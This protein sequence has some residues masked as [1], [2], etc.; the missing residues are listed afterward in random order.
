MRHL[1][2]ATAL[3]AIST[4]AWSQDL[5]QTAPEWAIHQTLQDARARFHKC[6]VDHVPSA[7]RVNNGDNARLN[8]R[9]LENGR[10]DSAYFL[11]TTL[12][13][14]A[15]RTCVLDVA[16]TLD[17]R[18]HAQ[19]PLTIEVWLGLDSSLPNFVTRLADPPSK[20]VSTADL[21]AVVQANQGAFTACFATAAARHSRL[22][23]RIE[24]RA[25]IG[26]TGAA[27]S[28]TV[29]SN[30]VSDDSFAPCVVSAFQGLRFPAPGADAPV[31]LTVPFSFEAD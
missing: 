21:L 20:R 25:A 19:K 22:A 12:Q 5:P 27:E 15:A 3:L 11:D 24:V 16:R 18:V 10:V 8:V 29:V 13:Q 31:L 2:I 26:S 30:T 1:L 23:G 28:V 14:E 7:S 6:Y 9:I 4:P 17:F